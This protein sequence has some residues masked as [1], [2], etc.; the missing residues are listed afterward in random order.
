MATPPSDK[1]ARLYESFQALPLRPP[2]NAELQ[3]FI[4]VAL[5]FAESCLTF[6]R[7]TWKLSQLHDLDRTDLAY[8][9]IAELF[10]RDDDGNL[11][12]LR[13]YFNGFET[14]QLDEDEYLALFRRLVFSK[15]NHQVFRLWDESDTIQ[16]RV[17]RNVKNAV[18][19][20]KHFVE[21]ERLGE[22]FIA[23]VNSDPLFE[24]PRYDRSELERLCFELG[25][26]TSTTPDFMANLSRALRTQKSRCRAIPLFTIAA[27]IKE[28]M[29]KQ[30]PEVT[31]VEADISD[32]EA[33]HAISIIDEACAYAQKKF[34][35]TYVR[36]SKMSDAM[37]DN[38]IGAVRDH[39]VRKYV[40]SDGHGLSQ[41]EI[42]S[43]RMP[44]MTEEE[45]REDHRAKMEYISHIIYKRLGK[46]LKQKKG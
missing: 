32:L 16:S 5:S 27:V 21:V 17:L 42:L 18:H 10:R 19:S 41:F 43:R 20:L 11:I 33:E 22:L 8:D 14:S 38:Y 13:A 39:L 23:P 37:L 29:A 35:S 15:V 9:C 40:E 12:E 44:G 3:L 30:L 25:S 36:T 7:S 46:V 2:S 26:L 45:Y 31:S 4:R 34:A 6:K 24:C 1:Y 28:V